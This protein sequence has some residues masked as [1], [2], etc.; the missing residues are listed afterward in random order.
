MIKSFNT[1]PNVP[2]DIDIFIRKEIRLDVINKLEYYGMGCIHSSI[3]ETKYKKFGLLNIDLYTEISYIRTNFLDQDYL[4]SQTTKK[5]VFN[6]DYLG[7]SD[8]AD[9]LLLVPHYLQLY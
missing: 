8:E 9:F 6:M 3:A 7:L 4:W 5:N 2:N 1:I